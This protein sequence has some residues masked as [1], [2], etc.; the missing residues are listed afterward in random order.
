MDH[1]RNAPSG[2]IG[3][4]F[5]GYEIRAAEDFRYV[6]PV[7]GAVAEAQGVRLVFTPDARVT[8]RL[9]GTGSRGAALRV[10]LEAYAAPDSPLDLDPAEAL[11]ELAQVAREFAGIGARL[12]R[13]VP[14]VVT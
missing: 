3:R 4:R 5:G 7:D 6:D 10:Y 8:F 11:G 9:S 14:S 1:L 12:G 13:T 2:A